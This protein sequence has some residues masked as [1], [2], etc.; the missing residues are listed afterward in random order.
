MKLG[1]KLRSSER[2]PVGGLGLS[3]AIVSGLLTYN[4]LN[5]HHED[6]PRAEDYRTRGCSR[7]FSTSSKKL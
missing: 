4:D 7:R 3:R 1:R 6:M 5:Y 2:R